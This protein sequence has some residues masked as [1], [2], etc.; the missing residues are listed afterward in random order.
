VDNNV[1]ILWYGFNHGLFITG[2]IMLYT[3]VLLIN[4]Y[5]NTTFISVFNLAATTILGLGLSLDLSSAVDMN[6]NINII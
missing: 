1:S 6:T 5:N 4:D 3:G 2:L